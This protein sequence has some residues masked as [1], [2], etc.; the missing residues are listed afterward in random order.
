MVPDLLIRPLWYGSE[1]FATW[2]AFLRSAISDWTSVLSAPDASVCPLGASNTTR[3]VAPEADACGNSFS[4]RSI[5]FCDC[6]PGR[7]KLSDVLVETFMAPMPTTARTAIHSIRTSRR[8]L[9]ENRP[10]R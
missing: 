8:R 4:N 7:L 2:G 6:V 1:T 10:S 3:A 5:A 9:N